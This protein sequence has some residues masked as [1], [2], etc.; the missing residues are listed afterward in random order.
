MTSIPYLLIPKSKVPFKLQFEVI[1]C[2]DFI[3]HTIITGITT[4]GMDILAAVTACVKTVPC[5]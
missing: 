2:L 4:T 5:R 1:L 3:D